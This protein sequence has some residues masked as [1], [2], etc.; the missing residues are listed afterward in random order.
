MLLQFHKAGEE[1]LEYY[2]YA[3]KPEQDLLIYL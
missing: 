2:V 3:M 1:K